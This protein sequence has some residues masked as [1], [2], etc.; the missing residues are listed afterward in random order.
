MHWL[1]QRRTVMAIGSRT[2]LVLALAAL[3]AACSG[4]SPTAPS[5]PPPATTTTTTPSGGT[6]TRSAALQSA[7]GYRTA[8][9]AAIVRDDGQFAVELGNDFQ[10]AASARLELRLCSDE[11]CSGNALS[12]GRIVRFAGRQNHALP[13]DG[14]K[15]GYV[16]IWCQVANVAFGFGALR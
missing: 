1:P 2:G 14:A 7:N 11:A 16:V 4:S 12:V 3:G 13:D 8:G 10:T 15:F 5:S 6:V 9:T